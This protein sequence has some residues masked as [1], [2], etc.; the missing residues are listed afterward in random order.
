MGLDFVEIMIEV[1][2]NFGVVVEAEEIPAITTVG[3]LHENILKKRK[4]QLGQPCLTSATFYRVRRQLMAATGLTK[5]AIRPS[6]PLAQLIPRAHR[7]QLWDTLRGTRDLQG[8]RLHGL[9]LPALARVLM[10]EVLLGIVLGVLVHFV[11]QVPL[12]DA[13]VL[14]TACVVP[15][16]MVIYWLSRAAA[17]ELPAGISTVG[18]LTLALLPKNYEL[19]A[20]SRN[21]T[22]PDDVWNRLQ[23]IFVEVVSV[24][25]EQVTYDA[26]L[27]EDLG[28]S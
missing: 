22:K 7:R 12:V 20:K 26:R 14:T 1:E 4:N 3:Q 5:R 28:V 23:D 27:V 2:E 21:L 15:L 17:V 13:I 8:F 16:G 25:R 10:R 6:T 9:R 24:R 19:V 18:D 11:G